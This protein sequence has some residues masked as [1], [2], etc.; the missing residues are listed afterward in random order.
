MKQKHTKIEYKKG[1]R[2]RTPD[3]GYAMEASLEEIYVGCTREVRYQQDVVCTRCGGRG[4]SRVDVCSSCGGSGVRV[5]RAQVAPGFVTQVQQTCQTCGGAGATVPPGATCASCRGTGM[6]SKEAVLPVKVSPG[7]PSKTR[8]VFRGMAD[9]APGMETGD[10]IVEVW[11]KKHPIFSRLGDAD[12]LLDRRVPLLDALCGVR[13][14][15]RHLDGG[16][17]EVSCP[18]GEIVRPGDVW[19]VKGRGM[20]K[21]SGGFGDLVLRFEVE[22]PRS[23][24]TP[25]GDGAPLRERLRPLLDP[26]APAEPTGAGGGAGAG[27]SGLFGKRSGSSTSSQAPALRATP[28][29]SKEVRDLLAQQERE[30]A[31]EREGGE[32]RRGGAQCTQM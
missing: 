15:L 24:P 3:A 10:I 29:R 5:T 27:W 9:E 31:A 18:E 12:L 21:R 28:Q 11:E 13:F 6:V 32:R 25:G 26:G 1:G 17:L 14:T 22:F 7:C 30:R 23:L 4:A 8:F 2:R 19:I 16:D 20:P